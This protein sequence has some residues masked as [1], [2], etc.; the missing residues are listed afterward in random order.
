MKLKLDGIRL[1]ALQLHI[2]FNNRKE[3]SGARKQLGLG[4]IRIAT[5]LFISLEMTSLSNNLPVISPVSLNSMYT[6]LE[7][8]HY[9]RWV[10]G[11]EDETCEC[12]V[13]KQTARHI[14]QECKLY[15]RK[16]RT[17]WARIR[18]GSP[19][20][21]VISHKEML[22]NPRYASMAAN[23]MR[24]TGLIGQYQAL[25]KYQKQGFTVACRRK[26]G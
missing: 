7:R 2:H 16:R 3:L 12:G 5:L 15:S 11:V 1:S 4:M 25:D 22:A 21:M 26:T 19:S 6:T 17:F 9:S 8:I 18:T 20:S 13:A 10:P 14:L 24:S 23:S